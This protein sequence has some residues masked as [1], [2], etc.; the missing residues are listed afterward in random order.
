MVRKTC[1]PSAHHPRARKKQRLDDE[2]L[3]EYGCAW[4]DARSINPARNP[5]CM[6]LFETSACPLQT[7]PHLTPRLP[8]P[9]P[10]CD[11]RCGAIG[12]RDPCIS[13]RVR[14]V[15]AT[16]RCVS[17]SYDRPRAWSAPVAGRTGTGASAR[18]GSAAA[19]G[20]G[21]RLSTCKCQN[22][23]ECTAGGTARAPRH[24]RGR[25]ARRS[26]R[27]WTRVTRTATGMPTWTTAWRRGYVGVGDN[28]CAFPCDPRRR[29]RPRSTARAGHVRVRHH[30]RGVNCECV[31][32]PL[33]TYPLRTR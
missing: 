22:G 7:T 1:E 10:A 23:G 32:T 31:A 11:A 9:F 13:A 30:R 25:C 6:S 12:L 21:R 14:V 29:R 17:G 2:C 18:P 28:R 8:E 24:T 19:G 3:S 15:R 4:C 20:G 5:Q 33:T 26:R 16:G 27:A